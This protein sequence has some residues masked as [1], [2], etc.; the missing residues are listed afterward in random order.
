MVSPRWAAYQALFDKNV[1]GNIRKLMYEKK[2]VACLFSDAEADA[3]IKYYKELDK[4]DL[5]L[6]NVDFFQ[7]MKLNPKT[8]KPMPGADYRNCFTEAQLTPKVTFFMS[9]LKYGTPTKPPSVNKV[10]KDLSRESKDRK[11]PRDDDM[12]F[13]YIKDVQKHIDDNFPESS[14]GF[15]ARANA[16]EMQFESFFDIINNDAGKTVLSILFVW[17]FLTFHMQSCCLSCIGIWL[18]L[19]SFPFTAFITNFIL[20]IKYFGFL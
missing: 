8:G 16:I 3:K 20:Q 18:I 15:I 19:L 5:Y 1:S 7:V 9:M 17:G 11:Y 14:S 10:D 6:M 13:A 2:N 12:T 4:S